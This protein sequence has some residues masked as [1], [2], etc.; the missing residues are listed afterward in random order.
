MLGSLG[1]IMNWNEAA[2]EIARNAMAGC[3]RT[4]LV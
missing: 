2:S 4:L 1:E 3:P